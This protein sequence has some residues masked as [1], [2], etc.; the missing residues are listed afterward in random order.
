M[1]VD[2]LRNECLQLVGYLK[3]TPLPNK[4]KINNKFIL[5]IDRSYKAVWIFDWEAGMHKKINFTQLDLS[6][7]F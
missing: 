5:K 3:E 6:E 7:I 2:G 1:M 4:I